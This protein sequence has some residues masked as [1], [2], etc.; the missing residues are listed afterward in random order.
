MHVSSLP[1]PHGIGD[2]GATA[3]RF[4]DTC[5]AAGQSWWQVLPLNPTSD[6]TGNSPYFSNSAFAGNPLLIGIDKLIERGLLEEHDVG[7]YGDGDPAT[8]DFKRVREF[9][10]PILEKVWEAF[11]VQSSNEPF[12]TFCREQAWWLDDYV[13]FT[14]LKERFG[15]MVWH[16]WPAAFRDRSQQALEQARFELASVCEREQFFQ[17]LFFEQWFAL[18]AYCNDKG[19]KIVGDIPIYVSYDSADVWA[20]KG[21]FKLDDDARPTGVSGVPP[22]YFSATGQLWNNPVYNWDALKAD[23]YG[24]WV[25]R[26]QATFERFDIVRIDHIRGLVQ[27]WEVPAGEPTAMNGKWLDVPTY[28][29]FDTLQRAI[30]GFPVI[31]EDLGVIT[32]DV[33]TMMN[34][35]GFP[36]MKVL[37]FAFGADDP[38]HP[39]LPH[40]FERNCLVYI[41]THDNNTF[42]GWFLE[43]ASQEERERVFAYV[44]RQLDTDA[45]VREMIRCAL[46]SVADVAVLAVQDLLALDG[47]ARMNHPA[48]VAGNWKWR[49]TGEQFDRIPVQWL[50]DNTRIYGRLPPMINA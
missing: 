3:Y 34:H 9:K 37:L 30:P 40:N 20:N 16:E 38:S 48:Q 45:L 7:S 15:G 4:A 27:F 36:G 1:S 49:L 25:R 14:A 29:F 44:G 8:T 2:L 47:G 23:R 6:G 11:S 22:D 12:R 46:A 33:R 19:L 35:Y 13:L 43:E 41:G 17:F 42:K 21:I 32:D 5:L 18:R 26:M 28:D 10:L 39:Y 50:A 24:W 31:A